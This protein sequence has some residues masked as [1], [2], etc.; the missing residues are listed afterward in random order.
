MADGVDGIGEGMDVPIVYLDA[1][2]ENLS[3]ARLLGDN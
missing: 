3:T 2:V 1:V